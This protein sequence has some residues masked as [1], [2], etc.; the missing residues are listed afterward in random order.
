MRA[1][2]RTMLP[3]VPIAGAM[4][5]ALTASPK[6]AGA[7]DNEEDKAAFSERC[8][9]RVFGSL[10]GESAP[11]SAYANPQASVDTLLLDEKFRERFARFIN[12]QFNMAPGAAP[13][14]DAS[15]YMARH[16]LTNDLPW[17]DMFVGKFDV[18]PVNAQQPMGEARV[19][20]NANG[21]GY[22][23]SNAWALRYA[24]NELAGMRL[25]TAYRIMQNTVGL[26]LTAT[27]ADPDAK[28]D[29]L[30]AEGRK[31]QNCAGCHFNNWYAL[32]L[33]ASVLGTV[34]R[35]GMDVTFQPSTLG[36]QS[37]LGGVMVK[38]DAELV[39][40]LVTNEAFDVNACRLAFKYL[41][42]RQETS[43]EGPVFD[44]CVTAFKK[45][46][47]ITSALATVAKDPS[48]CE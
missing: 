32:D 7:A 34:R 45:D 29:A 2:L 10:V 37:I 46:K 40:A 18:Q 43:C 5:F 26:T 12:S 13:T 35:N 11:A 33:V 38:D 23:R 1:S 48:F 28:P 44:A 8:A 14:E 47:K 39:Q 42:G 31:A 19:V 41:Y 6:Q 22:F 3:V 4:L 36:P 15:Y 27:T 30:S 21:L 25:V 20:T 24:G 16:V 9:T 17:A